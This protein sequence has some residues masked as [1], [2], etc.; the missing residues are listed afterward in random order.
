MKHPDLAVCALPAQI[1][2]RLPTTRQA[3]TQALWAV[4]LV[5]FWRS[6]NWFWKPREEPQ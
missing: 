4:W 1:Q 6:P 2:G 3:P 5:G